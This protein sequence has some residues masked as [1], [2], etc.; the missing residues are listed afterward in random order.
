ML[1]LLNLILGI[2]AETAYCLPQYFVSVFFNTRT[3]IFTWAH[4][5]KIEQLLFLVLWL[6]VLM[7]LSP[8]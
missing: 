2:T 1:F 3:L 6:S 7:W 5:T 8:G 4:A